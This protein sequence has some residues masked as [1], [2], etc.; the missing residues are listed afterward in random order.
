MYVKFFDIMDSLIIAEV[1]HISIFAVIHGVSVTTEIFPAIVL[2]LKT[3]IRV[4]LTCIL[5]SLGDAV[6]VLV[7]SATPVFYL[8][9]RIFSDMNSNE[10]KHLSHSIAPQILASGVMDDV[11]L[12]DPPG[13]VKSCT[14]SKFRRVKYC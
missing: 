8:R 12:V 2:L 5:V 10:L 11:S 1:I 14:I 9:H 3:L 4:D 7:L 13:D 6:P